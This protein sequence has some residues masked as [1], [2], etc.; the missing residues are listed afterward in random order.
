MS[1]G[2]KLAVAVSVAMVLAVAAGLWINGSPLEHRE[3]RIDLRRV[4]DLATIDSAVTDFHEREGRLPGSLAD[5]ADLAPERSR[6]PVDGQPYE[7]RRLDERR[8]ELCARFALPGTG[9]RYPQVETRQLPWRH[10]AGRHCF[11]RRL[12]DDQAG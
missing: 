7:Y 4:D 8:Y 9:M 3:R 12:K 2:R 1:G 11:V 5:L 6:D 10:E